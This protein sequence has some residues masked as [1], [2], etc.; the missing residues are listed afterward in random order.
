M[1]DKDKEQVIWK[2]YPDYPFI[3]VNQFGEVRTKDRYVPSRGGKRL[4][5]GHVLKQYLTPN[6]YMQVV[7]SANGKSVHLFVHRIAATCFLPNPNNYP[8]IN[9]K[10]NDRTNNAISNL[11]WCTHQY[12]QDYKN[13]FGTSQAELVGRPVIA[14][15]PETFEVFWFESQSE[16]ARQLGVFREN[17]RRVVKGRCNKT[18]GY[19]FCDA[20]EDAVEK[21]REKFGDEIAE[22]VEKLIRKKY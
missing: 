9:H 16:A 21:T 18:G 1:V 11:E 6:G 13:N 14:V 2:T 19:W 3:E 12:N 4:I 20:D 10:D 5:K 7:F 8:E 17:I 22:K 15:N